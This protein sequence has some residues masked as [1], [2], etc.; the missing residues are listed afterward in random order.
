M[1]KV[2]TLTLLTVF[3]IMLLSGCRGDY[4]V[5]TYTDPAN[6]IGTNVGREFILALDANPTTGYGWD[7]NFDN[8]KL[9]L[10]SKEYRAADTG[11]GLVGGGGTQFYRFQALHLGQTAITLAYRRVS[12]PNPAEVKEFQVNIASRVNEGGD[13]M[14]T[15]QYSYDG[16]KKI[17]VSAAFEVEIVRGDVYAVSITADDFPHIR[18]EKAGDTLQ[19]GRQG[20]EWF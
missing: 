4:P 18:V 8:G 13:K 16:F 7:E 12:D 17:E 20:I 14:A 9:K 3:S 1:K 5:N 19:L 2:L 10:L 15:K 6:A 11:A